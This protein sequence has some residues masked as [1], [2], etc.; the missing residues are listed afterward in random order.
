MA[1]DFQVVPREYGHLDLVPL[2]ARAVEY[3]N[4]EYA[5]HGPD[6]LGEGYRI[7]AT[8]TSEWLTRE[9]YVVIRSLFIE[10]RCAENALAWIVEQ[11]Y[12]VEQAS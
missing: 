5:T 7:G 9:N 3:R 6:C 11:G 4:R 10:N 1:S 2:T 12:T 8:I